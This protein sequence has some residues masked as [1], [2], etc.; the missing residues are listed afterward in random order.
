MNTR[1]Q[2]KVFYWISYACLQF[3]TP[4]FGLINESIYVQKERG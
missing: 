4:S 1:M 2:M 3:P